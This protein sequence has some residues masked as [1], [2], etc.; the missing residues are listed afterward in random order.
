MPLYHQGM[1]VRYKPV[2]GPESR[3]AES[4]GL[5]K[6]VLTST[7]QQGG[8]TIAASEEDPRYEIQNQNTGK[9]TMINERNIL[10]EAPSSS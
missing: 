5:I 10:G 4:I 2:G 8:R 9:K 6:S 1:N 7:T 3:T